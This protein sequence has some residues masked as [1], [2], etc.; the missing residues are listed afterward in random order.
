MENKD[1]GNF[2][3]PHILTEVDLVYLKKY[4]DLE[5]NQMGISSYRSNRP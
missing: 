4:W 5:A 1:Q 2:F 3:P